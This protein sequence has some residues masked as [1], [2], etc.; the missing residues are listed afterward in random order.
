MATVAKGND[1]DYASREVG[2][3]S[4]RAGYYLAAAEVGETL[5]TW[6]G[7]GAEKPALVEG[8]RD[9]W[10]PAIFGDWSAT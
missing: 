3:A 5:G 10:R 8:R 4:R 1:L 6:W 9:P 7:S 2:E